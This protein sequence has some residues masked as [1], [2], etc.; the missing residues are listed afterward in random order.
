MY[1]AWIIRVLLASLLVA[2][3]LLGVQLFLMWEHD[4][5]TTVSFLAVG[6]GD[7]ILIQSGHEQV[8]IDGGRDGSVLLAALGEKIPFYDRT[9]EVVIATHPDADHIGGL[10]TLFER[11]QIGQFIETG[12]SQIETTGKTTDDLVLLKRALKRFRIQHD[13]SGRAGV[14]LHLR[15]GGSLEI[16]YPKE[17]PLAPDLSSNEGSIV[18]RFTFGKTDFLFTGDLP[19]EEEFLPIV[20]PVEVLKAAHHGSASSTSDAW[21]DLLRPKEVI[22]SVGENNYGHPA[23]QVL[24]RLAQRQ[25]I[26]LRTDEEGSIT[27]FCTVDQESCAREV[28]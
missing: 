24:E 11:Y 9:I 8:L 20:Q 12:F 13:I 1:F 26:S 3:L 5:E 25:I 15:H 19:H 23:S 16:L 17:L 2:A 14:T 18:T 21:L 10:P 28:E 27:Y 22:L 4:Q 6:Q 7:A